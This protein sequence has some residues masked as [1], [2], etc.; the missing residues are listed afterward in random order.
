[1]A[2]IAVENF[3]GNV[4]VFDIAVFMGS[5]RWRRS[6]SNRTGRPVVGASW[7]LPAYTC[8]L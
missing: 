2:A 3:Q 4:A 7:A 6:A 1:V 8:D 5:L